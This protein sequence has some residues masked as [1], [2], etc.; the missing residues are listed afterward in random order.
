MDNDF[1]RRVLMPLLMPLGILAGF[2]VVAFGLSRVFLAVPQIVATMT[3]LVMAAYVL[4]VAALVTVRTRITSR[5]LAV[6]LTVA[7]VAV[8][9]AGA[10]AAA[11]G[12]RELHPVVDQPVEEDVADA[13]PE[14]LVDVPE[15]A[16]LF[17][18]IDIDYADAPATAEAGEVALALDNQGLLPHDVTIDELAIKVEAAGGQLVV[19]TVTLEPGTYEYYCS[20]PGHR[21]AGMF[22]TLEVTD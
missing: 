2:I 8:A 20:V 1:R 5:A 15:D 21:D 12:M 19:D 14:E 16:L 3:A 7:I 9:T 13:P 4:A 17:V 11:V 22:G 6:G 18:A 10:V